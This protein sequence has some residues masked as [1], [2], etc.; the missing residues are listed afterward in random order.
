MGRVRVVAHGVV[1]VKD[2]GRSISRV[3]AK[4]ATICMQGRVCR[5][6]AYSSTDGGLYGFVVNGDGKIVA[7]GG[8][9]ALAQDARRCRWTTEVA[10]P[11]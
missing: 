11:N 5:L 4:N 10:G 1:T 2:E 8:S 6:A 7:H 9:R 3:T